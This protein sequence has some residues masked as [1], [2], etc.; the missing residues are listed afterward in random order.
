M[1][2][3]KGYKKGVNLGGWLSQCGNNYNEEH[4]NTFITKEDLAVIASWGCDHVRL[5]VDYNVIQT[6]DGQF[7]ESGFKHIDDCVSWCK[8][9]NLK[10]V[11]DL[12]KAKGYVF[13][14]E[15][16]VGFFNDKALQDQFV[17]LWLEIIK[18]Y[19]QYCDMIAFELLNEVTEARFAEPWNDIY[20]RTIR[21]I[22]TINKEATIIVGGIY[23]SSIYG[24]TK[25]RKPIDS[26]VVY[27]FHCYSPMIFTHQSASWVKNMPR[28]Y[29][30]PYPG[31]VSDYLS[32]SRKIF[33]SDYDGDFEGLN[34]KMLSSDFFEHIFRT[35][36]SMAEKFDVALY[37]GEYGVIDLT[38]PTDQLNWYKD[39]NA[40]FNKYNLTRTAWTYKSMNFGLNDQRLDDIRD[41]LIKYL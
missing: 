8:D 1:K 41:E 15:E 10:M 40:V 33:G 36:L 34:C 35:A 3:F 37:C 27:T 26:N 2:E 30:L 7:I 23:N 18:R 22:R 16:Y 39:I 32:E 13:D 6:E 38:S 31:K 25:M 21:E 12:H 17:N 20:E 9:N 29:K 28:D 4:Y 19:G 24:L 11:F 14:D 5:P